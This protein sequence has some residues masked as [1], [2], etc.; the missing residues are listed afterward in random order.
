[1][2]APCIGSKK[3]EVLHEVPI[4]AVVG[5]RGRSNWKKD[6]TLEKR[7]KDATTHAEMLA[8][9]E[10]CEKVGSWRLENASL[11]LP[12]NLVLCAVAR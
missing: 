10:A 5:N 7:H 11:L 9:K 8:I 6:I 3:R 1:M 2:D 4:G 12:W